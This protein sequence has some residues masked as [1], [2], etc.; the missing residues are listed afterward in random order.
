MLKLSAT[1]L[2]GIYLPN[3]TSRYWWG[4]SFLPEIVGKSDRVGA[5][6]RIYDLFFA[7]S[8]LA[9]TP[10]EKS[11]VNTSRKFTTRFPISLR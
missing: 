7:R 1:K 11:S 5:K 9:I 10:S 4:R 3:Y 2:Y 6:S 8:A